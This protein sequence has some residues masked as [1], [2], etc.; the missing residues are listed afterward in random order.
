MNGKKITATGAS[1][2]TATL[3]LLSGCQNTGTTSTIDSATSSSNAT[4]SVSEKNPSS[5]APTIKIPLKGGM[6]DR[7]SGVPNDLPNLPNGSNFSWAASGKNTGTFI[8]A[9]K[10][11]D[12]ASVCNEELDPLAN[13]GWSFKSDQSLEYT[14]A[15]IRIM[16]KTGFTLSVTCSTDEAAGRVNLI[17]VKS[18]E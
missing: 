9:V 1:I 4:L 10:E 11:T 12:P 13:A 3:L 8:F 2:I 6:S 14:N 7:P 18:I 16:K 5:L 17:L 15:V